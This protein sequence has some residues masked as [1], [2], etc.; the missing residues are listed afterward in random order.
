MKQYP[1]IGIRPIIDA[2][3][4]GIRDELEGKTAA[5][6]KAAVKLISENVRYADGTPV[7]CVT[8]DT[9]ISGSEEAARAEA[10]FSAENV[11][12]TLSVTPSWCYPM[13]TIDIS[14]LTIKAIWGFNGT[15]R[16]GAVYLASAISAHNEVGRPVYSIYGHDVQNMNEDEIPADVQ[17]KILR[18]ARCAVAV[19]Q[20]RNKSYVGIGGVSM[21]IMGSFID[22][23]F[24]IRYLGMRPEWV[25]MTEILR[26]VQFGIYDHG[27]YEKALAWVKENCPEGF[28]KNRPDLKHTPEQKAAEWEFVVKMTLII[29][30]ICLGNPK[31]AELDGG[32]WKEE[33]LGHNAL[34]GGFQGQRAWTD[35]QPN[36][37]FTETLMNTSFDWNGKKQPIP[38][39]TEGDNCNGTAMLFANL[40]TGR[41]AGFSDV[42]C[43]W[44]PEALK[45][46]CG[47]EPEGVAAGGF[48]HIINSGS[49]C[50]DGSGAAKGA[51]GKPE[52]KQWWNMTDEDIQACLKAT[53]W[54]PASLT[55]F[56]GG[57]FSSHFLTDAE[58]PITLIR[59]N[60]VD[61]IGPTLQIAEGT[62]T[63]LPKDVFE[64]IDLRTDRTWPSTFFVPRT[65]GEGVFKDVY[66]VMMN[67]G[68]NH[69]AWT[70]GHIGADLI[71]L[72]SMLR[73]PVSMHNVPEN[74]IFRPHTWGA[75]GTKDTEA[76][77]Y[78]ACRYY[79]PLYR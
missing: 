56:R 35:W 26:R 43:Y 51:D 78:A 3:R 34:F 14:P 16:P 7:Q 1:K 54:C 72:A 75:F 28:D 64:M 74:E 13:E 44:S 40:L 36:G 25:D 52:M 12:A 23:N 46:K 9:S 15:E 49:T 4:L 5:M 53:D 41:A 77:D 24:F 47:W 31:L 58:M 66:S 27:E 65:T 60:L 48:M 21:G 10:K 33:A 2:R 42:R 63:K 69:G 11:V 73:I 17:E 18:F 70:Y 62:T 67:W 50:L 22:P 8:A 61:G 59:L 76:A 39:A 57:G 71:T 55:E 79:G 37:D 32:K 45:E 6:A 68:A 19:G 30:D 20:M 29:R 38:F